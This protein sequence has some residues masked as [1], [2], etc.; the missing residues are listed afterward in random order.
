MITEK[1][2]R[3]RY[4]TGDFLATSLAWFFFNV[5][6]YFQLLLPS[7]ESTPTFCHFYTYP[8]LIL[9]QILF[10]AMM[11]G[12]YYL[13]GYYNRPLFRSRLD[14]FLTTLT[15]A[16]IGSVIIFFLA[17]IDDPIPDK[18]SNIELLLMLWGLLFIVVYIV[19]LSIT[20]YGRSKINKGIL[21][22][23]M[24]I[25]GINRSARSLRRRMESKHGRGYRIV[26]YIDPETDYTESDGSDSRRFDGLPVIP[27][28]RLDE[29][30]EQYPLSSILVPD[31]ITDGQNADFSEILNLLFPLDIPILVSPSAIMPVTKIAHV[32]DIAG[33]PL[34]DICSARM[35]D[36][37][38]N[39]KRMGD[40]VVSSLALLILS[41]VLAAIAI[42]V[43]T[44]SRGPV[45]YRQTRI[46]YH[47]RPFAIIKFRTMVNDAEISGPQLSSETDSRIT[48]VGRFLRKYRLDELPQ[49]INVLRGEM[50]LVGPR[51]EREFFIRQILKKAPYYSLLHQVRPGITSWGMVRHGYASN[52]DEMIER[53]RYDL[54]Y[55]E[56]I[57]LIVDLKILLHTVNTVIKGKGI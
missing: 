32:G 36:S 12:L 2:Q 17:V 42:A 4:I 38:K 53:A 24:A 23:P 13:S 9:G 47:K 26:A 7:S 22:K 10:P 50:S 43:K 39:L 33:E 44:T 14:E 28:S 37:A 11:M 19:R 45:F 51:P 18:A 27:V 56:N 40:I 35:S 29:F 20:R 25:V 34:I 46:G 5:I 41:P 16:A 31:D 52:I 54:I 1:F 30:R 8:F 57:S 49:F 21:S 48:P 3:I 55:L 15:T 6:R